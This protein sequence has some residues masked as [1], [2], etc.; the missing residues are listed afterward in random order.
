[1]EK[2]GRDEEREVDIKNEKLLK[3]KYYLDKLGYGFSSTQFINI[4]FSFTGASLL[5]IGII[6]GLKSVF[7]TFISTFIKEIT[8]KREISKRIIS[9]AGLI[10][11]FSFLLLALA[12]TIKNPML[13]AISLLIGS[14][15]VAAYGELFNNFL[16]KYSKK[17]KIK[18]LSSSSTLKGLILISASMLLAAGILD[19]TLLNGGAITIKLI[20]DTIT[21]KLYGY[22]LT[23]EITAF[24]FIFSSYIFS[25]VKI[26]QESVIR[27]IDYSA[28]Y[29][30]LLEKSKSFFKNKYLL[31]LTLGMLFISVFQSII[32]SYVGIYVFQHLKN[33]WLGGF[34]NIAVMYSLALIVA[35]IGPIITSKINKTVGVVPMFVFGT[36]LMATLPLTIVY[37]TYFYPAIVAANILS[38]LG[39]ALIGSAQ[40][41]LASKVLSLEDRQ[42]FYSSAGFLSLIPFILIVITSAFIAQTRGLE[43]LFKLMGF[44]LIIF[45]VPIYFLIVMWASEKKT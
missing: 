8:E 28:Y 12:V 26:N 33:E 38:V 10:F 1:M 16:N 21:Q 15:G 13:F 27:A 42:N 29:N 39:A 20:G 45:V 31:V 9:I 23:F 25:K 7:N 5:L 22:L 41:I 19:L 40:G 35:L 4:L 14:V 11:G 17:G 32:N 18:R 44:G 30:K 24:A 34:M 3:K 37:N 6:N 36:C 2:E 43:Y